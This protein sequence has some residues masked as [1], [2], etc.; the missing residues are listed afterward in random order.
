M[1]QETVTFLL[2]LGAGSLVDA[3]AEAVP[4]EDAEEE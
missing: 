2:R 1:H 4:D 3:D